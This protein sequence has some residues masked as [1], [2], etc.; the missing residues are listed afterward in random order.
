M[1]EIEKETNM[2]P[3]IT[4]PY[5]LR[6]GHSKNPAGGAC[7]MDAINWLVHGK[8]GDKPDCACPV[9][10]KYVIG[11]NDAMPDDQRQRLLAFLPRIAGSRSAAH[12][13]ARGEILARG[14]VRVIAPIALDAAGLDTQAAAL[15]ALSPDCTVSTAA[16]KAKAAAAAAEAAE[17][18]EVA[19]AWAA[20]WAE[21]AA[22]AWAAKAA[23]AAAAWDAALTLLDDALSAGP[24]GEP[25]SADVVDA[26]AALYRAHGGK[27][28]A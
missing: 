2:Q 19:A 24:Q 25:W 4:W 12:K 22:A 10:G 16:A 26:G 18:A 17:V 9:I 23:A 11:L 14:A 15:R 13:Q 7:A 20:A 27:V 1:S 28:T 8:H 6:R 5:V 21:E 3:I